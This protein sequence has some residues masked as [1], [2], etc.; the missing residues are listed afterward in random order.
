MPGKDS[1][2]ASLTAKREAIER[3]QKIAQ[4][5]ELTPGD[6]LERLTK[7]EAFL[8]LFFQKLDKAE[9]KG[10]F[11]RKGRG[12]LERFFLVNNE[13]VVTEE[14]TA[15]NIEDIKISERSK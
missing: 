4:K 14:W 10:P 9:I 8:I 3:L 5:L 11:V 15:E 12:K 7:S 13:E 2:F 1:K 6:L